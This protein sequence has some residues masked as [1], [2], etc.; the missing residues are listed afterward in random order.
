MTWNLSQRIKREN[1][2]AGPETD[3]IKRG[4]KKLDLAVEGSYK[5]NTTHEEERFSCTVYNNCVT[6]RD[7]FKTHV[8]N[9]SEATDFMCDDSGKKC[10]REDNTRTWKENA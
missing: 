10:N 9:H 3:D 4:G 7:Q 6:G 1:Y 8:A 2:L 5:T